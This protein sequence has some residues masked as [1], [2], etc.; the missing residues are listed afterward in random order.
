MEHTEIQSGINLG[1][2]EFLKIFDDMDFIGITRTHM[3]TE[4]LDKMNILRDHHIQ[5]TAWKGIAV[6]VTGSIK[7]FF[8]LVCMVMTMQSG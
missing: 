4:V 8:T 7:Y 1:N 5:N 2:K 3:H 6:F